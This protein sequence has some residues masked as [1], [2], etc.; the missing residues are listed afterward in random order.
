MQRPSSA[1]ARAFAIASVSNL[2]LLR[3]LLSGC[4]S[5]QRTGNAVRCQNERC[6][7]PREW[8]DRKRLAAVRI[9][10]LRKNTAGHR[11]LRRPKKNV[12]RFLQFA[13]RLGAIRVPE[14]DRQSAENPRIA[15]D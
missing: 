6:V 8:R 15:G 13:G 1:T 11:A 14:G 10:L 9:D 5:I 7:T 2:R 3:P 4:E 12:D